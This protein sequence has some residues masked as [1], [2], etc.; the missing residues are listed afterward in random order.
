MDTEKYKVKT[1]Y[2]ERPVK[3]AVL[4]KQ[5]SDLTQ[6]EISNLAVVMACWEDA[7]KQYVEKVAAYRQEENRL[8]NCFWNDLYVEAGVNRSDPFVQR[9]ATIAWDR[10]H[11]AGF[12]E[13]AAE[14][15][16]LMP[17]YEIYARPRT[18]V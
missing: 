12:S 18:D 2:P 14:F 9:M 5:V 6:A 4:K 3:P 15:E 8:L 1:A 17:L 7:Q 10:G 13:V 11:S 16:A